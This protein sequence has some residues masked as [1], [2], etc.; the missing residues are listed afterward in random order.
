MKVL[1]LMEWDV[2]KDAHEYYEYMDAK[3]P[4]WRKVWDKYQMEMSGWQDGTGPIVNLAIM[5]ADAYAKVLK[6]EELQKEWTRLC[7]VV[8][9]ARMRVLRPELSVP[10]E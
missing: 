6:D 5:E 2:P 8:E 4:F 3:M 10:P 1:V 7:R 9:N